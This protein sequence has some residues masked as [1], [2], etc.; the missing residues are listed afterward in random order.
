MAMAMSFRHAPKEKERSFSDYIGGVGVNQ[1][2]SCHGMALLDHPARS[3]SSTLGLT[4]TA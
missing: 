1:A 4:V 2:H 3:S